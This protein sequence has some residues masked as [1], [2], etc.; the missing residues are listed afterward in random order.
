MTVYE[1]LI[2]WSGEGRISLKIDITKDPLKV[3][4]VF[5]PDMHALFIENRLLGLI[6]LADGK[7][8]SQ[9]RPFTA[10]LPGQR[11]EL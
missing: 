8:T 7:G 11:E 2:H 4:T 5:P 6:Y 10:R 1:K 9:D 3:D